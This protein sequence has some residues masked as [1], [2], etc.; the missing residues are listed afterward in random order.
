MDTHLLM[1]LKNS[2]IDQKK[3]LFV[4]DRLRA[5]LLTAS[6]CD[7]RSGCLLFCVLSRNVLQTA[8]KQLKESGTNKET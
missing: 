8:G 4:F 3:T 2:H 1:H 6:A 5:E 7:A